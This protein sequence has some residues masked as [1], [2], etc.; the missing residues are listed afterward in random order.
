[1]PFIEQKDGHH[2]EFHK[3]RSVGANGMLMIIEAQYKEKE[4]FQDIMIFLNTVK[5]TDIQEILELLL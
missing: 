5:D 4:R 2:Y 3:V 1:M